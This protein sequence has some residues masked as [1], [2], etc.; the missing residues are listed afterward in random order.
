MKKQR[1][2]ILITS[3]TVLGGLLFGYETGVIKGAQFFLTKYFFIELSHIY[4]LFINMV[5]L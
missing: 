4:S 2:L 3:I 1:S 5:P